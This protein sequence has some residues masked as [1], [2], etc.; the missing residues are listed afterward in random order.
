MKSCI[1]DGEKW[2]EKWLSLFFCLTS[3]FTWNYIYA[4]SYSW[5][6]VHSNHYGGTCVGFHMVLLFVGLEVLMTNAW[7]HLYFFVQVNLCHRVISAFSLTPDSWRI[8]LTTTSNNSFLSDTAA[9]VAIFLDNT[10]QCP[11]NLN[12]E[13]LVD[14]CGENVSLCCPRI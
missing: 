10:L 13:N 7:F 6:M 11:C 8:L 12:P 4:S 14:H 3:P 1:H 9:T 2:L 5:C